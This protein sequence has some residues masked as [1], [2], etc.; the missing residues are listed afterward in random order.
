M[1]KK[2]VNTLASLSVAHR[3]ASNGEIRH[4]CLKEASR[5]VRD[6]L[7]NQGSLQ[8]FCQECQAAFVSPACQV[9]LKG[10]D[11]NFVSEVFC[12]EKEL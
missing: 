3:K 1:V 10:E 7:G 8:G 6:P 12:P 11:I 5:E 4:M 9:S 2:S